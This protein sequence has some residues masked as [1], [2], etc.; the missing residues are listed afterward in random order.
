MAHTGSE[1]TIHLTNAV[2]VIPTA[3]AQSDTQLHS[4]P[5]ILEPDYDFLGTVRELTRLSLKFISISHSLH[6]VSQHYIFLSIQS[7]T[8][9]YNYNRILI[10]RRIDH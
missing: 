8:S 4:F 6:H 7:S 9:R 10:R 3:T 1:T 2:G 5:R